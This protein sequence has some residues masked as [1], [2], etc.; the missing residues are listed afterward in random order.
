[1]PFSIPY[2]SNPLFTLHSFRNL[3]LTMS[4]FSLKIFHGFRNKVQ[5]PSHDLQGPYDLVSICL[6]K[7]SFSLSLT[8][9]KPHKDSRA[10]KVPFTFEYSV[11]FGLEIFFPYPTPFTWLTAIYNL[12]LSL[13]IYFLS[14]A[15]SDSPFSQT[16]LSFCLMF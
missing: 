5:N 16:R 6:S 10:C 9:F 3:N 11:L 1:M 14:E 4:F 8:M 12:G 7:A 15:F 2:H 13:N